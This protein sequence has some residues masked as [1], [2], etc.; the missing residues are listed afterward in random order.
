MS[1][2][3]ALAEEQDIAPR[4][5]EQNER[6]EDGDP[7]TQPPSN[8][9]TSTKKT[10]TTIPY[11]FRVFQF[12]A[13]L[14][15]RSGRQLRVFVFRCDAR[16]RNHRDTHESK[17]SRPIEKQTESAI[18]EPPKPAPTGKP[19]RKRMAGTTYAMPA[20]WRESHAELI[21]REGKLRCL[22]YF[23]SQGSFADA[24]RA[25]MRPQTM[26]SALLPPEMP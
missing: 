24:E 6:A 19:R 15:S 22:D 21:G 5:R 2:K 13:I 9:V 4:R 3:R 12:F 10:R 16:N 17:H 20:S 25:A 23:S 14:R 7:R 26:F 11:L 1:R 8:E 18:R